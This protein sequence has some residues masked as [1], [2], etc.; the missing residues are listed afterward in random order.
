MP[1]KCKSEHQIV[2]LFDL[3]NFVR[4]FYTFIFIQR[5]T[6]VKNLFEVYILFVV[7]IGKRHPDSVVET[8]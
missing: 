4:H 7:R 2:Y 5:F 8:R 3:I 6:K 1:S